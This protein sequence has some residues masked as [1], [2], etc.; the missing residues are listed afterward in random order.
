MPK[1]MFSLQ[2][3][4]P[5]PTDS[6][7]NGEPPDSDILV[8]SDL[9]QPRAS[10]DKQQKQKKVCAAKKV[11]TK[12]LPSTHDDDYMTSDEEAD[13]Q[14]GGRK[15]LPL[16][17]K[18]S[19]HC[20]KVDEPTKTLVR[21]IGSA[22][23]G[24]TWIWPRDKTCILKHVMGCGYVAKLPGGSL[25]VQEAIQALVVKVPGLLDDLT[26]RIEQADGAKEKRQCEP[27][28]S[29]PLPSKR[30]KILRDSSEPR[31]STTVTYRNTGTTSTHS[32]SLPHAL[33]RTIPPSFASASAED[34]ASC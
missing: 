6:D 17:L 7:M 27:D 18:V 19:K 1:D 11:D 26:K 16:L 15:T 9:G 24:K 8:T 12:V 3:P 4:S 23:C 10:R 31:L 22:G 5:E 2:D 32:T 29:E 34:C 25:L 21:C 14:Y 13:S 20:R 33:A 30:K 28:E